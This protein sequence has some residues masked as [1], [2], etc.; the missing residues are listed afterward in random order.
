MFTETEIEMT[1]KHVEIC[2]VLFKTT[3][4][5]YTKNYTSIPFSLI[6]IAKI[7]KVEGSVGGHPLIHCWQEHKLV[8]SLMES[9]LIKP[10]RITSVY[11][12]LI[13]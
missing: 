11:T 6:R 9:K 8:L 10:V 4:K 3:G 1:L 7:E 5:M 12:S 13:Q 2:S